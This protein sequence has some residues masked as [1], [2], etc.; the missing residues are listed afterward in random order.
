MPTAFTPVS[1]LIGGALIGLA[2]TLLYATLGRIAGISGIVTAAVEQQAQRGWRI[3]F[4]LGLILAGGLW[5]AASGAAPRTGFPV[6]WLIAAG[7]LVGFGT[8]LGSGCTSGHGICGLSRLS[9]RSLVAV[10]VFMG[11]GALTVYVL[12]HVMGG[13][14]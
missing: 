4:L 7:L 13:I 10:I 5:L 6:P 1:A 14:A 8:R 3:G 2:A 12:R 9:R 11:F